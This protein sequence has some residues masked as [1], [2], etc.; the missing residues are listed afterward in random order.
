VDP[1][2]QGSALI[3]DLDTDS[4][5]QNDPKENRKKTN[6]LQFDFYSILK[7]SIFVIEFLDPELDPDPQCGSTTPHNVK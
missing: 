6:I 3:L 5:E 2:P 7:F 1:D 4:G